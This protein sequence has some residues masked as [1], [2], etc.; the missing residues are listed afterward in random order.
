MTQRPQGTLIHPAVN[1][2]GWKDSSR[3]NTGNFNGLKLRSSAEMRELA[4]PQSPV[5]APNPLGL[6]ILDQLLPQRQAG[7]EIP[8]DQE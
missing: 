7:P 6:Q 1:P 5:P 4:N 3:R 8:Q 2:V